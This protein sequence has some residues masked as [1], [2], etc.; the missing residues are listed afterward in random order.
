MDRF[1]S[2]L[3]IEKEVSSEKVAEMIIVGS[4]YKDSAARELTMVARDKIRQRREIIEDKAFTLKLR[5]K[6]PMILIEIL[7]K[8]LRNDHDDI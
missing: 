4:K 2:K 7:K 5:S 1:F 8:I 6:H 3:K